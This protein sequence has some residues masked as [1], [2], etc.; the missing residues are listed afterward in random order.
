[1][2][3][4]VYAA[5]AAAL[6]MSLVPCARAATDADLAEIRK[7]IQSLKDEYELRIRAL[8]ERLKDAESRAPAP[9]AAAAVPAPMPS[10]GGA[11]T[12][13]AAFNPA[14]SLVLQGRYANLSQD[15]N[16]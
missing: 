7:Q 14:I 5:A 12:G 10:P 9:A 8:E 3:K 4:T 16:A 15:P 11:N 6:A 2:S 1:M 13:L